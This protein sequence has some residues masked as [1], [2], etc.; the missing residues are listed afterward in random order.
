MSAAELVR[1]CESLG[2]RVTVE[3]SD[4]RIRAPRGAVSPELREQLKEQT[5]GTEGRSAYA[6]SREAAGPG[7][8]CPHGG[9]AR[10]APRRLERGP[11]CLS[12]HGLGDCV[13]PRAGGV[14]ARGAGPGLRPGGADVPGPGEP[15]RRVCPGP[16]CLG[17]GPRGAG[18][19]LSRTRGRSGGGVPGH[20]QGG[21]S[22]RGAVGVAAHAERQ[23]GPEGAAGPPLRRPRAG[24]G[25]SSSRARRS[26][27]SWWGSGQPSWAPSASGCTITSSRS[28]GA[29]RC[30][31]SRWRRECA[32]RSGGRC[33]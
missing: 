24:R 25:A 29:P 8:P 3:G 12:G 9:G 4:L 16:L 20:A 30:R 5:E 15:G 21:S 33:R 22:V 27:S 28:W 31:W 18:G 32:R 2:I 19:R 1:L 6:P 26:S 13:V 7:E 23:G 17:R 11:A 10:A 14:H